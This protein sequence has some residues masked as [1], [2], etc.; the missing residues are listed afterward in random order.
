LNKV[1]GSAKRLLQD[2]AFSIL[3]AFFLFCQNK[4]NNRVNNRDEG[5]KID[6]PSSTDSFLDDFGLSKMENLDRLL[7]L[8]ALED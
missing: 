2:H 7:L 6:T 4:I 5:C 8:E 3:L 1:I